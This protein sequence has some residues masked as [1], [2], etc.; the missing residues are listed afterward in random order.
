MLGGKDVG[1]IEIGL[2]GKT[3]S[4]TKTVE[5]FVQLTNKHEGGSQHA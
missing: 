1:K 5:N 4:K 3:V 2:V